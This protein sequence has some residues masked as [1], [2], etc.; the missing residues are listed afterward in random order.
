MMILKGLI[1]GLSIAAPVGPIGILC[2]R[3]TLNQGRLHGF[4]SGVGAATADAVYGTVAAFGLTIVSQFLIDQRLWIQLA[5]GL[6][7]IFRHSIHEVSSE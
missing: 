7:L 2:I 5:G 4:I 6:F 1:I 3:R